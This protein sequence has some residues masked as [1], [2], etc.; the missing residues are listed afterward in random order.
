[1]TEII[2]EIGINHNGSIE[3]CKD[4]INLSKI[5]GIKYV[6]IQKRNPDICVPEHQKNVMR[7]T[8]WGEMTYLDYK[9]RIEFSEEQIKELIEYS[10]NLG[11]VFFASV[12][13]MDSLYTMAKYTDIVKIPSALITDIELCK[14]ARDNF[15]LLIVSTGMSSEEEIENC[16]NNCHPNIIM[17]TN[18]TY[19]CSPDE[20]NLRYIEYLEQKWGNDAVI[21]Y[22]GHEYGIVTTFAAVAMGAKWIE[23]HITLDQ[24]M[25]GSD[26][27]SSIN[28]EGLI[29]LVRG[30]RAIDIAR[31]YPPGPRIEFASEM[32]KK[33][34]LRK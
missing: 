17:H 30:I 8:P 25:W 1:M 15:K 9:K 2:A 22:S 33:K 27:K 31:K 20:L 7:K 10:K 29:K 26:H 18:S 34:S 28:P 16:V 3:L 19:P 5:A 11:I 23:R 6:K 24:T 21:G 32:D 13:D 12:W 4:L 14:A